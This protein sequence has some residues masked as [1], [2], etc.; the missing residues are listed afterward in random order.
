MKD[1]REAMAEVIL[2]QMNAFREDDGEAAF[3]HAS[4]GIRAL[5]A[6]PERFMRMVRLGYPQIYR[7]RDVAIRD[8]VMFHGQPALIVHVVGEDD[9][10]VLALY[11]MQQL[12]DE[13]WRIDGCY[14]LKTQDVGA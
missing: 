9:S 6:T 2:S 1:A 11:V 8:E 13:S 10:S 5:F 7:F 4:A 3:A 14:L 12:D